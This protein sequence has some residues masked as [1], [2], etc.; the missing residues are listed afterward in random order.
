MRLSEQMARRKKR[1]IEVAE[2]LEVL[3]QISEST[4]KPVDGET[5]ADS[6]YD[7]YLPRGCVGF[8][9]TPEE[10]RHFAAQIRQDAE[11]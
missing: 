5:L 11:S 2:E 6:R 4:G 7:A 1:M 9:A 10:L 8:G 3:A